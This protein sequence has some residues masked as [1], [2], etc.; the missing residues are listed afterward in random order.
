M[1]RPEFRRAAFVLVSLGALVLVPTLLAFRVR[2]DLFNGRF[3]YLPGMALAGLTAIALWI[4]APRRAQSPEANNRLALGASLLW[5]GVSAWTLAA[6]LQA[7]DDGSTVIRRVQTAILDHADARRAG[8]EEVVVVAF[9]VPV[10]RRGVPLIETHLDRALRPPLGRKGVRGVSLL[11]TLRQQSPAAWPNEIERFR[12]AEGLA[13]EDFRYVFCEY[14]PPG[15]T[16]AFPAPRAATGRGAARLRAPQDGRMIRNT[17]AAPRFVFSAVAGATHYQLALSTEDG[18]R[19]DF[20]LREGQNLD[21]SEDKLVFDLN[22][23]DPARPEF[24]GIWS[25]ALGGPLPRPVCI[26]WWIE[27]FAEGRSLG[28]SAERRLVIL[29]GAP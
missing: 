7:W 12:E 18:R 10:T 24:D 5:L 26:L 21:R 19:L 17:D 22:R 13:W 4:P 8:S 20:S 29:D 3:F 6:N 9:N 28:L 11:D 14:D 16:P 15:I 1:R 2:E 23:G 27:A 25:K